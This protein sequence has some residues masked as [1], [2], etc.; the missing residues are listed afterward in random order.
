MLH[1]LVLVILNLSL[2]QISQRVYKWLK[3]QASEK[4]SV[5][6]LPL[7]IFDLQSHFTLCFRQLVLDVNIVRDTMTI[8]RL[9]DFDEHRK[10][11][12]H[13]DEEFEIFLK[14]ELRRRLK[15]TV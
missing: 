11:K 7:S 10:V 14:M 6:W 15:S 8:D 4:F 13:S 12:F 1:L 3:T 2:T 9:G 5:Q